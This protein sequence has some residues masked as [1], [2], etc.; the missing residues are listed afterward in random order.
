MAE[1]APEGRERVAMSEADMPDDWLRH[2]VGKYE[3][4][5]TLY[6]LRLSGNLELARDAVQETFLR[7]CSEENRPGEEHLAEWLYRVC[8]SRVID[9]QRKEKRMNALTSAH[10]STLESTPPPPSE[11]AEKNEAASIVMQTLGTLPPNQQEALRLKF[12][13]ELS[14]RQIAEVMQMT[15]TNVGFLIHTGLKSV[16]QKMQQQA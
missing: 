6:A 3:K 9:I 14:Y 2:L 5:L 8:R 11:T 15:V 7:L 13:H 10:S 16:R 12:Q 1:D 4:R